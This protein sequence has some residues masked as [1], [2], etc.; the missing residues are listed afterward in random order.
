MPKLGWNN[1][2]NWH[3]NKPA[4]EAKKHWRTELNPDERITSEILWVRQ[5]LWDIERISRDWYDQDRKPIN[6]EMRRAWHRWTRKKLNMVLALIASFS[7]DKDKFM[8]E[9]QELEKRAF[10]WNTLTANQ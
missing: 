1:K 6:S 7:G 4:P 3:A 2:H 5:R 10:W 8:S 9:L